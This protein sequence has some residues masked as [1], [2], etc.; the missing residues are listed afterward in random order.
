MCN[1]ANFCQQFWEN[2][3]MPILPDQYIISNWLKHDV[4]CT[5][6]DSSKA[7]LVENFIKYFR[8]K[9]FNKNMRGA[10]D[11]GKLVISPRINLHIPDFEC[12]PLEC[13]K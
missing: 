4:V 7:M 13:H 5:L 11:A 12:L 3:V 2:E 1:C 8:P 6:G 9:Y 10:N